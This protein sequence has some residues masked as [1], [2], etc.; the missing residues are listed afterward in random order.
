MRFPGNYGRDG[1]I[2][3]FG[4]APKSLEMDIMALNP[5][6]IRGGVLLVPHHGSKTSSSQELLDGL[7]PSTALVSHKRSI[8]KE[9]YN[10]YQK[11]HIP[12]CGTNLGGTV[13]IKLVKQ[14]VWVPLACLSENHTTQSH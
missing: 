10:R 2:W 12:L 9:V 1:H 4:D 11:R 7:K 13:H 14:K 5:T 3:S 6:L 8:P